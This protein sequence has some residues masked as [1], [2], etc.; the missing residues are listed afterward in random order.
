LREAQPAPSNVKEPIPINQLPLRQTSKA[1]RPREDEGDPNDEAAPSAVR[2]DGS[3]V[4]AHLS[5]PPRS[6]DR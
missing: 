1:E 4:T 3:R 5:A 2:T 6:V